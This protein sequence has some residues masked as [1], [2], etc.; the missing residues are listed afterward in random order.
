MATRRVVLAGVALLATGLRRGGAEGQLEEAFSRHVR[1][2][3]P[4]G[5][6]AVRLTRAEP[7]SG[8]EWKLLHVEGA[9]LRLAL[10][11]AAR[12]ER[13]ASGTPAAHVFL[14]EGERRPRPSLRVDVYPA[15]EEA[16]T[17]VDEDYATRYAEEYSRAAF[18]GRFAVTDRGMV[19]LLFLTFDCPADEWGRWAPVLARML[20]SVRVDRP[21]RRERG[22]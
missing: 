5:S 12:V 16:P 10:P 2:V 1:V 15:G 20:V 14:A 17:V 8:S 4:R 6:F 18:E 11:A 19:E 21:A 22:N 9:G 13:S 3:R 7:G